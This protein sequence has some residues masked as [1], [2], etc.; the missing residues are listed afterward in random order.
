M[1]TH[2]PKQLPIA[3][4]LYFILQNAK[5]M[6]NTYPE[7]KNG[8][9]IIGRIGKT[10]HFKIQIEE[11]YYNMSDSGN[12]VDKYTEDDSLAGL[13]PLTDSDIENYQK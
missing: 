6:K 12:I 9:P 3:E 11:E 7:T 5:N 10:H 4:P 2:K 13:T 8:F 1:Q